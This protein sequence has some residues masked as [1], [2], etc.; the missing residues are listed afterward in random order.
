MDPKTNEAEVREPRSP[1]S[2]AQEQGV[3]AAAE[4][5]EVVAESGEVVADGAALTREEVLARS[6]KENASGD[7]RER[8]RGKAASAIGMIAGT[9]SLVILMCVMMAHDVDS[10]WMTG[11]LCA[12]LTMVA[13]QQT[14]T[15]ALTHYRTRKL[16]IPLDCIIDAC[17]AAIWVLWI[18]ELCGVN[19]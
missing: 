8:E 17:A 4:G 19:V 7:E 15:T 18:L 1:E 16:M 6:R 12:N 14:A 9:V 5:T 2:E 10:V 13:A 11:I 3:S